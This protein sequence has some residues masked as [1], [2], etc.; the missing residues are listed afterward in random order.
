MI[1]IDFWNQGQ[2][3]KDAD[4]V[5]VTFYPNDGIYRGNLYRDGRAIA[6]FWSDNSVELE[7]TFPGIFGE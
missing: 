3:R 6:D 5:T 4:R 2:T 1:K 7:K